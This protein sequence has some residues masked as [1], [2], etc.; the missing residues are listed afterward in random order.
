MISSPMPIQISDRLAGDDG[1]DRRQHDE[2][3]PACTIWQMAASRAF[4]SLAAFSSAS[5]APKRSTQTWAISAPSRYG[6]PGMS[7]VFPSLILNY[8]GQTAIVLA[9]APTDGNIFYRLCP[10]VPGAAYWTYLLNRNSPDE[11][12]TGANGSGFLGLPEGPTLLWP[13]ACNVLKLRPSGV[14]KLR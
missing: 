1:G 7:I 12:R 9:G 14:R 8:A 10:G 11:L 3:R 13:V 5:P 2:R 4:S 6:S